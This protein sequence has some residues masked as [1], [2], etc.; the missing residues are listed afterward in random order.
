[1]YEL[2]VIPGSHA[3]RAAMLTLDHKRVPYE[4]VEFV[5]VLHPVM[6]RLHGFDSGGQRRDAAGKRTFGLRFGDKLGTVPGLKAGDRRIATNYRIAR[7]LDQE[8][9]EPALFPADPERR[10]EVEKAERWGNETL[11]MGAAT[12]LWHAASEIPT[13]RTRSMA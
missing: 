10:V 9:P 5:T 2:Y 4:T 6:S 11:Q 3:C 13:C 8:H 7:F 12:G 1:M